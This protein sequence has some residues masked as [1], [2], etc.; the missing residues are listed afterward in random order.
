[1]IARRFDVPIESVPRSHSTSIL[2]VCAVFFGLAWIA[3]VLRL[4][5]RGRIVRAVGW[6]DGWMLI[7]IVSGITAGTICEVPGVLFC[8]DIL[9]GAL[10]DGVNAHIYH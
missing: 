5:T 2:T 1:M 7:S 8:T 9:L 6:D 3:V 10:R 4:W